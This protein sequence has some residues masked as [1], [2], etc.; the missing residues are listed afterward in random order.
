MELTEKQWQ[1][2]KNFI[3]KQKKGPKPIDRRQVINAIRYL[4]RTGCPWRNLPSDFPKWKTVDN[5]FWHWRNADIWQNIHDALCRLVRKI[6]GKNPTPSA[7]IL[8]SQSA[9]CTE[10]CGEERGY[11]AAKNVKGRMR[12]IMVDTLGLIMAI[13]MTP[14][15][16]NET[17]NQAKQ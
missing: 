17:P 11:D 10:A 13:G 5:G 15:I 16:T 8:D 9:D 2:I 3:P 6:K 7:G 4:V 12:H 14:K 1:I